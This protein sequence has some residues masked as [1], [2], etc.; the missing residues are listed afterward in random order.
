MR[1]FDCA[2]CETWVKGRPM[3]PNMYLCEACIYKTDENPR[4]RVAGINAGKPA[5]EDIIGEE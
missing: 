2:W 1:G 3:L 4:I 5:P